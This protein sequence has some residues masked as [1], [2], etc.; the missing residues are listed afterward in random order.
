MML[1]SLD[2]SNEVFQ[3]DPLEDEGN[4]H[5]RR[6]YK[7]SPLSQSKASDQPR[8]RDNLAPGLES[9]AIRFKRFEQSKFRQSRRL[10]TEVI[11]CLNSYLH[12]GRICFS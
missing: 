12:H 5:C 8:V 3:T 9:P 7:A 2:Q 10:D 4:V 6:R 1:G 11:P